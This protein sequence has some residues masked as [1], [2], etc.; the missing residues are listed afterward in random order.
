MKCEISRFL[1]ILFSHSLALR[2]ADEACDRVLWGQDIVQRASLSGWERVHTVCMHE[3]VRCV[4][5][6]VLIVYIY[7]CVLKLLEQVLQLYYF[8][9]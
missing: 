3:W 4:R 7:M 2:E 1:G 9:I 6:C 5:L 8:K